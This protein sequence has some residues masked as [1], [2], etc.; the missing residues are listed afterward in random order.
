MK[1]LRVLDVNERLGI[2]VKEPELSGVSATLKVMPFWPENFVPQLMEM[3]LIIDVHAAEFAAMRR[4]DEELVKLGEC[5]DMLEQSPF[6]SHYE[7]LFHMLV[8]QAAHNDILSRV[9]EGLVSLMEKNNEILHKNLTQDTDWARLVIQQHRQT[10]EAIRKK[11]PLAAAQMMRKHLL[12]SI[13]RYQG[14]QKQGLFASPLN[15][16]GSL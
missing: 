8:V 16:S 2:F 4:K 13:D 1:T 5:L 3:R 7:F 15:G 6:S 12:E 11:D 14:M 10:L 9:Y